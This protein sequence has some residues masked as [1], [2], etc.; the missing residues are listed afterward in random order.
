MKNMKQTGFTLIELMI[1][2]AIIGII[3]AIG[4]PSY[5]SSIASAAR[6]TA[7]ADLMSFAS[8]MERHNASNYTYAG[9]A[10][11]GAD[12]GAP[13]IFAAHSPA[14]EPAANKNYVLSIDSVATNGQGFV[15]KAVPDTSS[16]VAGSGNLFYYSD[17]RKA[18]DSNANGTIETSEFCWGC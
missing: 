4:Y 8:A 9:A 13:A 10:T 5:K 6:S 15:I 3:T 17:G 1:V 18:W 14:S 11:A 7:Q 2:I 12:T 16:S